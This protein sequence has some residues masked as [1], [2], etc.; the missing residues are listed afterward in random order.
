MASESQN[1]RATRIL[2]LEIN[3][4]DQPNFRLAL[5]NDNTG[6]QKGF[7]ASPEGLLSGFIPT[8]VN[9]PVL[10]DLACR[11]LDCIADNNC[12]D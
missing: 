1:T 2:T 5:A 10:G 9:H 3:P 7:R 12:G 6:R 11:L 8:K 4:A